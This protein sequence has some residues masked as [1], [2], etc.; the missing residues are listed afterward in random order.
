MIGTRYWEGGGREVNLDYLPGTVEESA[1]VNRLDIAT[2]L[3]F[4][5]EEK[6]D[7]FPLKLK[8][9]NGSNTDILKGQLRCKSTIVMFSAI[10]LC[11]IGV[12]P[13]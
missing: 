11:Y 1:S 5:G 3:K 6:T 13:K 8:S 9:R 7:I 2:H 4:P 10:V 12:N